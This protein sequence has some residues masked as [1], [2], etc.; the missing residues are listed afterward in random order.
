MITTI[1]LASFFVTGAVATIR[2]LLGP[3]L[4][5]RIVALDVALMALMSGIAV[6][7]VD[8]GTTVYLDLLVVIAII[9]FTA[10][11]AASLFIEHEGPQ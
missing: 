3:T 2:L 5:D 11:V 4:A 9:G 10:T 1:A 7:A 8:S 6:H